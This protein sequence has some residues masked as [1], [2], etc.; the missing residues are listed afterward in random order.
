[1]Y[2]RTTATLP[3]VPVPALPLP[4]PLDV[5]VDLPPPQ[6]PILPPVPPPIPDAPRRTQHVSHPPGEWWKVRHP[7]EPPAE[8][9]IIWSD[10]EEDAHE[11][12][13]AN[14]VSDPEPRTFRQAMH[15]DQSDHWREAATLTYPWRKGNWIWM[16]VQG[17]AQ[18]GWLH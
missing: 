4:P 9:P 17:K 16:G 8:P 12:Q 3:P 10:D 5:P 7:A 11:E 14:S 2:D 6:L 1:M 15:G 18:S 13:L